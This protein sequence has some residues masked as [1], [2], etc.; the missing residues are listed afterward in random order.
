MNPQQL[1]R[2][3][4]PVFLRFAEQHPAIDISPCGEQ[5]LQDSMALPVVFLYLSLLAAWPCTTQTHI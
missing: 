3:T 2:T 5:A 1:S 4:L